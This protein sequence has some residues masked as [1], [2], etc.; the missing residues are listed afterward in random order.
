MGEYHSSA[1]QAMNSDSIHARTLRSFARK[2]ALLL[3]FRGAARWAAVWFFLWG[4]AALVARISGVPRGQWLFFGLLGFVP[5][6]ALAAAREWRRRPAFSKIRAAYDHLNQCGGVIMSE[7]SADMSAWQTHLP[8]A[9]N[10][11]L[12]WRS[13]RPLGIL[14]VSILFA[15][16]ALELPDRLTAMS[17]KRPLEIGN[18]VGELQA[19]VKTLENE[20]ILE[21]QKADELQKQL[22]QLKEQSSSLDPNKTWEAL[23]HIKEAN[24]N[25]AHE[26]TEEALNNM[27]SLTEA[28][29]LAGALESAS[30]SGLAKDTA[31]Q[32]AQDLAG[33]LKAAKLEDG[34]LKGEIPPGL[35]SQLDGLSKADLEKLLG[36]IQF[37][38][39]GLSNSVMNLA[40]LK[41][42]D[43][44][45]LAQCKNAGQ[46]LNTNALCAYLSQCTN[47]NYNLSACLGYGR[48]GPGGGGGTGPMTWKDES[49]DAGAKFKEEV[50][51][52]SSRLSDARF[53]GVS[54]SAPELSGE[55]AVAEHGALA[56]A[57]GSGGGA[58][59]Q[60]ILPEHKQT[61]QRFFKRED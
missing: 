57:Q 56:G 39:N 42:I 38:K 13:G 23:D 55:N 5:L 34:L 48:G 58:N 25:L 1:G 8:Q 51:P 24:Q 10:P 50:L 16:V 19:E 40:N 14:G 21:E 3:I 7:E 29:A 6:A 22:A 43:P 45:L 37:N 60:I 30:D 27:T 47:G 32:A 31:T 11:N 49:S 28:Q 15:V 36:A 44:K 33:L 26:A 9:S 2:L 59:S 61:V 35:L 54:R 46:C 18:L 4:V 41:L 20:R 12:R 53:V 52:P 17:A